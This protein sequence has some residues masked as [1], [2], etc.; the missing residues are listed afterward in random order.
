MPISTSSRFAQLASA[1]FLAAA[2]FSSNR[3][4][5]ETLEGVW[6]IAMIVS[7]GR[8][9]DA[10]EIRR[11]YAADGRLTI[12]GQTASL[13]MP[14]TLQKREI[15]VRVDGTQ[16]PAT[17][18]IALAANTGGHGV[19]MISG[20]TAMVCLASPNQPRATAFASQAGSGNLLLSLTRASGGVPAT[21]ASTA[22]VPP[23]QAPQP[24]N[25]TD[26]QLRAKLIGTWGHQNKDSKRMLTLNPDG[27]MIAVVTWTDQFKKVF[28]SDVRTSGNWKVQDGVVLAQVTASTD[29]NVRGQVYS[30]RIR[31]INDKELLAVDQNGNLRQEWKA[32][33][34]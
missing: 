2:C 18:D 32:P 8:V 24:M 27:S 14:A 4:L 12:S 29:K 28:H 1:A 21:P 10:A 20:N 13:V 30:Y 11:T 23:V 31:S 6:D 17:I 33:S 25:L 16:V 34:P 9:L 3:T 26:E 22:A 15:P 19:V 5:G 7:N